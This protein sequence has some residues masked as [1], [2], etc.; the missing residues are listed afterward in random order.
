MKLLVMTQARALTT[1][2]AKASADCGFCPVTR[3]PETT[4]Y[5]SESSEIQ[6]PVGCSPIWPADVLT[7]R[8]FLAMVGVTCACLCCVASLASFSRDFSQSFRTRLKDCESHSD[9]TRGEGIM[10]LWTEARLIITIALA[11]WQKAENPSHQT[12]NKGLYQVYYF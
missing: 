11:G 4:T 10:N 6:R 12:I 8:T 5:G 2:S 7:R 9:V 3:L 1:A